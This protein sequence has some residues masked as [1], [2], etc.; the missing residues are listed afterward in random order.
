L[1][2]KIESSWEESEGKPYR[3]DFSV[4]IFDHIKTSSSVPYFEFCNFVDQL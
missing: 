4:Y 2:F 1:L 3:L